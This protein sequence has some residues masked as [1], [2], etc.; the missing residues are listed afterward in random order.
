LSNNGK[1]SPPAT[2]VN[3]WAAV[4][5]TLIRS[6]DKGQLPTFA[7]AAILAIFAWRMPETEI[8]PCFE[9]AISL[10]KSSCGVSYALNITLILLW[11]RSSKKQ[12]DMIATLV[13]E[14]HETGT[15]L[16]ELKD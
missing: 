8:K 3:F 2:N 15:K 12:R 16:P 6:I 11:A 4:Q 10:L 1:S 14:N 5:N 13:K 7:L 9:Q